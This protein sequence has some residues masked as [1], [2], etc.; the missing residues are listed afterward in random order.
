MAQ[1][2]PASADKFPRVL[3]SARRRYGMSQSDAAAAL[4][5]TQVT[6]SRWETGHTIVQRRLRPAVAQFIQ[7]SIDELESMLSD[8]TESSSSVIPIRPE[9]PIGGSAASPRRAPLTLEQHETLAAIRSNMSDA[10]RLEP[11]EI[12]WFREML[13][14]VGLL[15]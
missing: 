8:V 4:D 11:Y 6:F 10:R 7:M 14:V 12:E 1:T 9:V 13:R 3:R 15:D 2:A 5:V